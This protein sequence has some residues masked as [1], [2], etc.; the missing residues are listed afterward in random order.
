MRKTDS[1][2]Q[3]PGL[4]RNRKVWRLILYTDA[5]HANICQGTGSICAYI[6]FITDGTSCCSL[7]WQA[8]KIK[9]VVRSTL[10]AETLGLQEG[11][12]ATFY[13]HNLIKEITGVLVPITA[14]VDNNKSV[15]D[16]IH[17]LTIKDCELT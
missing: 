7:D 5:V 4:D 11:F 2:I 1:C 17:S 14:D 8:N 13:L 15:V 16:A 6:V 10:A 12:E 9:R 3:F